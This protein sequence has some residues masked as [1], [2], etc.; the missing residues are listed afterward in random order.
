ME[1]IGKLEVKN[2]TTSTKCPAEKFLVETFFLSTS[3]MRPAKIQKPEKI[4]TQELRTNA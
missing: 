1:W 4:D 3:T 2:Y